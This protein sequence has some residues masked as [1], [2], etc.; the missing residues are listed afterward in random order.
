MLSDPKKR[1]DY[2]NA[3][4]AGVAGFS[5]EDLFGGID[6]GGIFGGLNFDF[7]NGPFGGFFSKRPRGPARGSNLEVEL[8][9][10]LDRVVS[11]G[12][13]QLRVPR[14]EV[15]A[16]CKGTGAKAG[17]RP[18]RCEVCGGSGRQTR[19]R[20]EGKGAV[21][22]QQVTV[23]AACRGRGNIVDQSCPECGGSGE[24]EHEETLSVNIPVGVE[25]GMAL[26]IPGRGMPSPDKN[27]RPGDLFVVVR[28]APD[29]RFE[30]SGADLWHEEAIQVADAALGTT[31]TVP[32]VDKPAKVT[33][34]AGTQPN[35]VLRLR[36]KGLPEF[37]GARRGGLYLRI[38]VEVPQQ[39]GAE[40]RVL[41]ERLRG[42]QR[43]ARNPSEERK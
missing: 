39:L 13:E 5:P 22:I 15:C 2:D 29:P 24:V 38:I 36:N 7:G 4:F 17:T 30:R 16:A 25:E 35:A 37:G 8:V 6:F 31:L 1:K 18:R 14:L 12:E 42:L 33:V 34:P 43:K 41:Y 26:R 32:T 28:S 19:S 40:E 20:R 21:L 27:G 9:V 10:P 11:G 23:C 3:G